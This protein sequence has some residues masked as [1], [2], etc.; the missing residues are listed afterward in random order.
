MFK[1]PARLGIPYDEELFGG[2]GL[3]PIFIFPMDVFIA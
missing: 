1:G 2:V 3:L